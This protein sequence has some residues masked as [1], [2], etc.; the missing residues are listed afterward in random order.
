[1][2]DAVIDGASERY[3]VLQQVC[4]QAIEVIKRDLEETD[5]QTYFPHLADNPALVSRSARQSS[6]FWA[7]NVLP[8]VTSRIDNENIEQKLESLLKLE[9]DARNRR[10]RHQAG[11]TDPR[12]QPI[13]AARLT[14]SDF[15]ELR[16]QQQKVAYNAELQ[17]RKDKVASER[18]ELEQAAREKLANLSQVLQKIRQ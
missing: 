11:S 13:D 16:L 6:Q 3:R 18:A 7:Q 2:N 14:A 9:Q 5:L 4:G 12:D 17:A 1:M 8:A 10:Y 15:M